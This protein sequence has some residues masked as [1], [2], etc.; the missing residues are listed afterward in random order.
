MGMGL[1]MFH[2]NGSTNLYRS[3]NDFIYEMRDSR[4][5]EYAAECRK[6]AGAVGISST[7]MKEGF[8]DLEM[9]MP[10]AI[11]KLADQ[12]PERPVEKDG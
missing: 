12:K 11:E 5:K 1:G 4:S 9:A 2:N 10:K 8:D 7:E 6:H 3:P